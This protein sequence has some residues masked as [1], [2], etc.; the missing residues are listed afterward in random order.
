MKV[1]PSRKSF[2]LSK[3]IKDLPSSSYEAVNISKKLLEYRGQELLGVYQEDQKA[4]I[5]YLGEW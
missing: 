4:D 1:E 2:T 3:M 5:E